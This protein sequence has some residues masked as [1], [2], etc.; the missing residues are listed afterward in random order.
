M[1]DKLE[2]RQRL[3]EHVRYLSVTLGD[4]SV[5]RPQV[6][7]AAED[8]VKQKFLD[9]SYEIERQSFIYLKQEV[10][11]IIAGVRDPAGYYILGAHFD[12]VAG[13]PG[14]DDNASAVAVLLEAA[15]LAR[16]LSPRPPWVFI[17]FTTEEPPAFFPVHGQPGL[18]PPGQ[19]AGGCH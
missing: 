9:L 1:V 7:K 5:Y 11:N 18:R 13:T 6:L 10:A 14:A 17:G 8:Y 12:T 16:S 19:G 4:R 2:L 3:V 15:R